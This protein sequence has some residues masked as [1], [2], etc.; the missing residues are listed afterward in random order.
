MAKDTSK[1]IRRLVYAAALTALAVILTRFVGI[2]TQLLYLG[3]GELPAYVGGML[4]GPYWGA[5]IGALGDIIGCIVKPMGEY[6]PG[7]T[8]SAAIPG[9]VAGLF[10]YRHRKT[11]WRFI[12]TVVIGQVVASLIISPICLVILYEKAFWALIPGRL[13]EQ[14]VLVV[15]YPIILHVLGRV[16]SLGR[17]L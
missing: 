17:G 12:T 13:A 2:N 4:L 15:V 8:I 9:L 6:F 1:N 5:A 11:W 14:A 10:L 3:F 16:K 7:F